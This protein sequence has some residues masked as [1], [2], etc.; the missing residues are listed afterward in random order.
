MRGIVILITIII[1]FSYSTSLF[2][3]SYQ[4]YHSGLYILESNH[5][6]TQELRKLNTGYLY[7]F[8]GLTEDRYLANY[9]NEVIYE[10][11]LSPE[12]SFG[13]FKL[14]EIDLDANSDLLNYFIDLRNLNFRQSNYSLKGKISDYRIEGYYLKGDFNLLEDLDISLRFKSVIDGNINTE[15]Y[16]GD[17][18][19]GQRFIFQTG[20]RSKLDNRSRDSSIHGF[21]LD[22]ES[23]FFIS[24]NFALR[25]K[26]KNLYSLISFN[27]IYFR[28][29]YD[30]RGV[31]SYQD[32]SFKIRPVYYGE[33]KYKNFILGANYYYQINPYLA[34]SRRL[35]DFVDLEIM[36]NNIGF[37]DISDL[38]FGFSVGF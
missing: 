21:S 7:N 26:A 30:N 6:N 29:V 20:Y 2:A 11:G 9:Y 3:D 28:E 19:I 1:L 14:Q 34:Y 27:N 24:N 22:L 12:L 8:P 10:F 4:F 38:S 25:F 32:I 13:I 35:F 37:Q 15:Y 31:F 18:D 36:L 5:L 23:E 17:A 16:D 33:L